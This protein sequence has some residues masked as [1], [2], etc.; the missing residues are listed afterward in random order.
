MEVAVRNGFDDRLIDPEEAGK[1]IAGNIKGRGFTKGISTLRTR[2][3]AAASY[4][5]RSFSRSLSRLHGIESI[6]D[7]VECV[8]ESRA[9]SSVILAQGG[10]QALEAFLDLLK[11]RKTLKHGSQR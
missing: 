4:G 6:H 8:V 2:H 9:D 11:L 7:L 10:L 1:N 3:C 5:Q